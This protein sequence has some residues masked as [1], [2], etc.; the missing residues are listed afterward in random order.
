MDAVVNTCRHNVH[1]E[2]V[3]LWWV[4]TQLRTGTKDQRAY[5][6]RGS[7]LVGWD[8]GSIQRHSVVNS[9]NE[10]IFGDRRHGNEARRVRN[11]GS[12]SLGTED[13]DLVVR[14][15]KCFH[16]LIGLL[17]IVKTRSHTMNT[18]ERVGYELWFRPFA[19]LYAVV[20]LDV[21]IDCK[22]DQQ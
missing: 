14:S 9:L 17:S 10:E 8:V 16:A 1:A 18:H 12:I 4:E 2:S 15:A 11:S 6:H 22:N 19:S 5:I 20:G 13:C 3:F 7:G 21:S